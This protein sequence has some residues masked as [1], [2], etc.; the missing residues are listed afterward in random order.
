MKYLEGAARL[1]ISFIGRR[2]E[3]MDELGS[4]SRVRFK[5]ETL[6]HFDSFFVLKNVALFLS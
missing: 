5:A 2:D 3:V 4:L 6:G 1:K